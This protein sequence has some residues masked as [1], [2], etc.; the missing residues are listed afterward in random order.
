M[1]ILPRSKLIV[2]IPTLQQAT[3]YLIGDQAIK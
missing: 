3:N 2:S 1:S